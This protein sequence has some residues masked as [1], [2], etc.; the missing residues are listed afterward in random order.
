MTDTAAPAA[1]TARARNPLAFLEA[2]QAF[3]IVHS[4]QIQVL[5]TYA[6]PAIE[7]IAGLALIFGVWTREAAL[8]IGLLLLVF[9]AAIISAINAWS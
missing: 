2:I 5:S 8:L 7:L 1:S 9:I 6:M 3:K 4:T